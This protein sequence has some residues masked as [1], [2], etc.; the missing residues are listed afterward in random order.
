MK[1]IE[2]ERKFLVD[3]TLWNRLVKPEGEEYLQGYLV[4]DENKSIRVRLAGEKGVLA[5]KGRMAGISRYE[6]EYNIPATEAKELLALFAGSLVAKTRYKIPLGRS[7]WEV[8]VFHGENEGLIVAEIELKEE[9]EEFEKPDWL[10][11]E[12]TGDRRYL[13]SSLAASPFRRW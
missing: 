5:I 11:A 7:L 10:A 4:A 8:D 13:N 6:F 2:T 9:A 12:V 3:K 1:N